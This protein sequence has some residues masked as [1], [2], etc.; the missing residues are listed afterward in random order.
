MI[1]LST[2]FWTDNSANNELLIF[3]GIN[4]LRLVG[5]VCYISKINGL[6]PKR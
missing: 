5:T 2:S 1:Q 4:S 6:T 3:L